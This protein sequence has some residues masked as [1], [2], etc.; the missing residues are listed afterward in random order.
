MAVAYLVTTNIPIKGK[1]S[2]SPANHLKDIVALVILF[3]SVQ[4]F[5]L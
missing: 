2:I 3:R 1:I 5:S 4:G